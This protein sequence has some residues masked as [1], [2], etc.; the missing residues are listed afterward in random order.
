MT[1]M[2]STGGSKR[3]RWVAKEK[4]GVHGLGIEARIEPRESLAGL[5]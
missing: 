1:R 4:E 5:M 3:R 2:A